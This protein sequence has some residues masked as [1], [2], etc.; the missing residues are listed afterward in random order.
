MIG[1][2]TGTVRSALGTFGAGSE[3]DDSGGNKAS[4]GA[5]AFNTQ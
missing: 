1:L 2:Q 4:P 5:W 3:V